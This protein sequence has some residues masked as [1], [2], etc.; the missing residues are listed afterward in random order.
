LT[1]ATRDALSRESQI[2]YDGPFE[3]LPATTTDAAGLRTTAEYDYRVFQA[4]QVTDP[5]DNST[6]FL[7][8]PL[9]FLKETW[10]LGKQG[11]VE[12]DRQ[13]A[14]TL[15]AYS[16]RP[17]TRSLPDEV[18]PIHVRTTRRVHHDTEPGLSLAD[19]DEALEVVEYSDGFGR[20]LQTRARAEDARFGSATFGAGVLSADPST[21][22]RADVVGTPLGSADQPHVVVSGWQRY[23]NKGRV[24]EKYE[25]F[26]S[27]GWAYR[28]PGQSE[29]GTKVVTSYDPRGQVS[30]TVNPDGSER[31]VIR[32]VPQELAHLERFAPTPWE[33][34]SYDANDNAGRTHPGDPAVESYEHHW[35]T[36][37]SVTLDALGRVVSAIE[38]TRAARAGPSQPL[39]PVVEHRI[40]M[41]VDLRGNV[42]EIGDALGR[43]ALRHVYDLANR[44]LR[45]DSID[46]GTRRLVL[47]AA[48]NTVETRDSKGAVVL[49]RYDVLNRLAGLWARDGAAAPVTLRE[50]VVYGD[51]AEAAAAVADPAAANLLGRVFEYY[52]EA[53]RV[54]FGAYDFKGNPLEKR[55]R[56]VDDAAILGA[57][58]GPPADWAIVPFRVDWSSSP[59]ALL[60][61]REYTI[62]FTYDALS[63]PTAMRY[64][65]DASAVAKIARRRYS[66]AGALEAVEVDGVGGVVEH[67]A[68]DAKGQRT[69]IAFGNGVLTRY[70]YSEQT[71]R[72]VR[73]RTEHYQKLD[74]LTYRPSGAVLQDLALQYDHIGNVLALTD[75]TPG[76]GVP[77]SVDGPDLLHRRFTY[78]PLYRLESATGRESDVTVV[79]PPACHTPGPWDMHPRRSDPSRARTYEEVFHYD[80]AGNLTRL[81]HLN[82]VQAFTRSFAFGTGA[83]GT[84]V[85]NRLAAM[86][87]GQDTHSY[88]YD[89]S[90]NLTRENTERH[91]EWDHG[92]RLRSFRTQAGSAEPCVY[93][94]YLH[95]AAGQLVMALTRHQGGQYE[96]TV[97]IDGVYEHRRWKQ[98]TAAPKTTYRLHILDSHGRIAV[99]R[100]GDA[101][102]GGPDLQYHLGDH[103][104]SSNVVVSGDGSWVNREEYTAYGETSFGSFARKR[105]RF[106]GQEQD[107]HSGMSRHGVRYYMPWAARWSSCDPQIGADGL[108][109]YGY[110]QNN[111]LRLVDRSGTSSVEESRRYIERMRER[112][113]P[114]RLHNQLVEL[115]HGPNPESSTGVHLI[116]RHGQ[117]DRV[118]TAKATIDAAWWTAMGSLS[119]FGG[120]VAAE[121]LPWAFTF[122]NQGALVQQ[123]RWLAIRRWFYDPRTFNWI[124]RQYW[125]Q[126]GGAFGR[127]LHHWLFQN[128]TRWIP[129]AMRN[130]GLNLLELPAGLNNWASGIFLRELT[131][132][133]GVGAVLTGTFASF[134]SGTT[135]L[136]RGDDA[137]PTPQP[138]PS[139][140]GVGELTLSSG[141]VGTGSPSA[142]LEEPGATGPPNLRTGQSSA[143]LLSG[144]VHGEQ[145]DAAPSRSPAPP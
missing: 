45:S 140:S 51:S 76:A 85:S 78:D 23:D 97:Y 119:I 93:T 101:D 89:G 130:A 121:M 111:P 20:L 96:A 16:L 124:S 113:P 17:A 33:I 70:A 108:S 25:P 55:R 112:N 1:T 80:D 64:P 143:T 34:Y 69:L 40:T 63:R 67:I 52:D 5:N 94:H 92:N 104:G 98:A 100:A 75:R 134:Y 43:N 61:P 122:G 123:Y 2:S 21:G 107:E 131:I 82:G 29:L 99:R 54:R 145:T 71:T 60:N 84:P 129:Q 135:S 12:G 47:D 90:G 141:T 125:K 59:A 58:H 13:Q 126:S 116:I 120:V 27:V 128:Q 79:P 88:T 44:R 4:R 49:R 26:L 114:L 14:S 39:A 11:E 41:T 110:A 81:E 86:T 66:R 139:A 24:T 138:D 83:S 106:T 73:L 109:V 32:G 115:V 132:R 38:R 127:N 42:T 18:E 77:A 144:S 142:S 22:A 65:T 30:R 136:L 102:D 6:R 9:G 117:A 95:D 31:R 56:V 19:G 15:F 36:P 46:A 137:K 3:L 28:R 91:F 57:F 105:Y 62:S 103:L 68:Y 87:V 50:R 10:L 72:L 35:D 7:F 37:A 133:G 53:G 118:L 74:A 8:T 48:G